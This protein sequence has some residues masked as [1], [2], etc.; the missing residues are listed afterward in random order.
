MRT[1]I[2]P[3][4]LFIQ[5]IRDR[6]EIWPVIGQLYRQPLTSFRCNAI[7][8][9]LIA[10]AVGIDR[11]GNGAITDYSFVDPVD[12]GFLDSG[13]GSRNVFVL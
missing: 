6:P 3:Y 10:F 4:A 2:I 11:V 13:D 1:R 12:P 5:P 8:L 9:R 7:F